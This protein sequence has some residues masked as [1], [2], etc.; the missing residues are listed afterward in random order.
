MTLKIINHNLRSGDWI[1][2]EDAV[3]VTELNDLN[4][5]V[6]LVDDDNVTIDLAPTIT[7]GYLGGGTI[8]L[9]SKIDILT[10]QFNFYV[11]QGLQAYISKV[12]F[13]V[14][15]TGSGEDTDEGEITID[16]F[17]STSTLSLRDA[18]IGTDTILGT[19]TVLETIPF[20]T[21]PL[22]AQMD[23]FWHGVYLQ[24]Q[25]ETIQLRIFWDDDQM[26]DVAI[27]FKDFQLHG[28]IFYASPTNQV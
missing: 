21:I 5:K 15:N 9:V 17:P 18:A 16:S 22:E 4:F 3:G 13:Y 7:V 27:P 10:K 6:N 19:D 1:K 12:D 28:M 26:R 23:R 8:R 25:G 2:I 11:S 14:E 20:P 24:A